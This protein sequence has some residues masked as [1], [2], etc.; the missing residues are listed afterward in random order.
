MITGF[1]HVVHGLLMENLRKFSANLQDI[2]I[3]KKILKKLYAN[4]GK[5][6]KVFKNFKEISDRFSIMFPKI[7]RNFSKMFNKI[8]L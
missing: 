4:F 5:C 3:F 1:D 6:E 7:Q 2:K 8:I